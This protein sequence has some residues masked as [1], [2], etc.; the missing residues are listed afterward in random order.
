MFKTLSDIKKAMTVGSV[1]QA[2]W[3]NGTVK[4][5]PII[6]KQTNAVVFEGESWLYWEKASRYEIF[7]D[8]FTCYWLGEHIPQNEIMT[9]KFIH[10]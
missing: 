6:R 3:T 5:R 10:A 4:T 1:W 7:S 2:T 8:G 9:Y